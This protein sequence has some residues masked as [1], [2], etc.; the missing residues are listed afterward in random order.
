MKA[1]FHRKKYDSSLDLKIKT[2]F[3]DQ[4]FLDQ[5]LLFLF[6]KIVSKELSA[7]QMIENPTLKL[8]K[9]ERSKKIFFNI[10]T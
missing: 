9:H 1:C 3:T 8:T 5:K 2:N 4:T 10:K 6:W 7:F